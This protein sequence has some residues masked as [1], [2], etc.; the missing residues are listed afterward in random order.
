MRL[1]CVLMTLSTA[2]SFAAE[3]GFTDYHFI[4]PDRPWHV[5]GR[6]RFVGRA[7]FERHKN[8]HVDYSDAD[9]GVYYTQFLN[10]ENSLTYELGYDYLQFDWN[11][12]RRFGQ[13]NFHYL[14]GSLG[15]VS[16]TLDRWRWIVNAGFSVDGARL[17]FAKS[18]V[19]H[20]MLWGR[21]HFA[22]CC[23]VHVGIFGWYG[24]E[25]GHAWPIFGFDWKFNDSWS[26]KAIFPGD[27]SLNYDFDENWSLEAAYSYFGGPYRKYPRRAHDGRGG[28]HD[29][30]FMVF[31]NGA[32]LNFKYKFEHLLRMSIGAGWDFGGW[33]FIK[34][35]HNHH[36]KYFH[37]GSAPYAQATLELTF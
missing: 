16:T 31:A 29:P 35:Q 8:G 14:V 37:Y 34:D 28:F 1:Y 20:A 26:A 19:G 10:D 21:Y 6:Y 9:G 15:Y 36:G 3:Y 13:T 18:A 5:E 4:D 30:I 32:E 24:V 27:Y 22:D 12:N 23:G 25:N 11:K 33:I 2:A 7:D 17:D